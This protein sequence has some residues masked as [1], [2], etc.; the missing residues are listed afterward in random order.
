MRFIGREKELTVL[1][2]NYERQNGFVVLYGRRRVGKTTLIDEFIRDKDALYF[3]ATEESERQNM[4]SFASV[5]ADFTGQS[6]LKSAAFSNW[7]ALFTIFANTRPEEKKILVIDEFQNLTQANPAFAS[8]FQRVWDTILSKYQ[9]MVILCGSYIRMMT[10]ET[11]SYTSPLY[12]RRT[13]QIRLKPL[14][15]SE[16][17]RHYHEKSFDELMKFYAVTGGVPKYLEFFDNSDDIFENIERHILNTNGYLYEEPVFLLDHE[18]KEPV[19]YFSILRAVAAGNRKLADL[20]GVLEKKSNALSPYLRVLEDLDIIERRVPVTEKSPEKSRRGLYVISDSF[21]QFWFL[22]VYPNRHEL[23]RGKTAGVLEKI[24]TE[25]IPRY[26]SFVY[27]EVCRGMFWELCDENAVP[28]S[29]VKVGSFW[30]KAVEVDVAAVD[31]EGKLFFGECKYHSGNKPVDMR[32]LE[33]LRDKT[34]SAGFAENEVI[35]GLFSD[36]GFTD[37]VKAEAKKRGVVLIHQDK[38]LQ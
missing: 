3:F 7:D 35:F 38:I 32:V 11:L 28:F 29:P 1:Q 8:V 18:V 34:L 21:L 36:S 30:D 16:L 12:G 26:L 24:R 19:N 22:F 13:A 17:R 5:L 15:F 6:Y 2:E 9:I 23:E 14:S 37:D 10:E 33:S 4:Q 25:F 31:A 27:E 20:A